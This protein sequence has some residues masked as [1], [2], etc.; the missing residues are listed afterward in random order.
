MQQTTVI[1]TQEITRQFTTS[2][3]VTL[4]SIQQITTS[5]PITLVSTREVT[6]TAISTP[7]P[8]TVIREITATY[9]TVSEITRTLTSS[10]AIISTQISTAPGKFQISKALPKAE[11]P[12]QYPSHYLSLSKDLEDARSCALAARC[13][14][15]CAAWR[16]EVLSWG[17]HFGRMPADLQTSGWISSQR[18]HCSLGHERRIWR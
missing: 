14:A 17:F 11:A 1:S 2:Y 18:A 7:F 10:Y 9:T 8:S 15:S 5:Y 13:I 3:P 4:T 12:G 16:S 6:T